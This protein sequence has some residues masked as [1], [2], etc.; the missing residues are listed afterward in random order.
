MRNS[1][2]GCS[3]C[4]RNVCC[5]PR[6]VSSCICPPGPPG[7]PGPSGQQGVP[8]AQGPE[9]PPGSTGGI[10]AP[11]GTGWVTVTGGVVDP[12]ALPFTA[13]DFHD[14][15]GA[16]N[17]TGD[18]VPGG[19]VDFVD[20]ALASEGDQRTF[21]GANFVASHRRSYGNGEDG[22]VTDSAAGF[23]SREYQF[24]SWTLTGACAIDVRNNPSFVRDL[25]DIINAPAGALY[26]T[27]MDAKDASVNVA[28]AALNAAGDAQFIRTG[29]PGGG[30]NVFGGLAGAGGATNAGTSI[31][32]TVVL[33]PCGGGSPGTSGTAGTGSTGAAGTSGAPIQQQ[34]NS[35]PRHDAIISI[36]NGM[37]SGAGASG[38]GDGTATASGAGAGGAGGGQTVCVWARQTIRSALNA[39]T[40]VIVC[41]GGN[42]GRGGT[43]AA[44]NRGG[45]SPSSGGGGGPFVLRCEELLG[46]THTN[47]IDVSGGDGGTAGVGT[48]TGTS[49]GGAGAG[50]GGQ[51]IVYLGGASPT[52]IVTDKRG[53]S[54]TAPSGITGGTH[55]PCLCDL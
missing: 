27:R 17:T 13:T 39:N 16:L 30:V 32:S 20:P 15:L 52:T 47:C 45:G 35:T 26:S 19:L 23:H 37:G 14:A 54:G 18:P 53:I 8:G 43:P 34:N 51:S 22:I 41:R 49:G 31:A 2:S 46:T 4:R 6:P 11:E 5:C 12:D 9:G 29:C 25:F 1:K 40:G 24:A 50:F 42:G 7:P 38:G 55:T 10:D 36:P 48:G 28:G 44:G 3:R 21:D 33:N